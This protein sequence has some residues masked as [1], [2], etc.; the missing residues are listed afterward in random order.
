MKNKLYALSF[1]AGS[2]LLIMMQGCQSTGTNNSNSADVVVYGGTA[3]AVTAAVQLA[4]MDKSVIIVCPDI[5][6][7]GMS[8]SGLGFTDTGNKSVIGGLS[9]EFYQR[10]YNNYQKDEAWQWQ[11]R[12]EYG[13]KGQG[14]PAIDG[15]NRT[16]WIFEP[17]VAEQI[18]EDFISE[19]NIVVYRDKWLDRTG[20]VEMSDGRIVSVTMTDGTNY[21]GK[22][23]I[24]ATYEG[25]LMAAAGISYHVGRE[26]NSVYNEEWNGVQVGVLHHRHHFAEMKVSPYV[27]PGDSSSGILPLISPDDPGKKGEGDNRLQAYCFRTCLT[28]VIEN[29]IPFERPDNYDS[30]QYELL[31]RVLDKGWRETFDKFD[32]IPNHKTDVN[33]HGPFSFDYIGMNYDYPEASYE[34]RAEIIKEHET[35]QKGLLYFYTHD[36]RIL[37]DIRTEMNRWGLSKDEFKDNGNWPHQIYVREARR[38]T[39]DFV[40]TE[41]EVL[42]KKK[43]LKSIG[44]GSYTLDSHNAQRYIMEDGSVQNE[45]DIGIEAEKPYQIDMGSILPKKAEC[46]NLIVPVAVSCSHIAFGSIRMEP[47]FMILGQSAAIIAAM[48]IEENLQIHDLNYDQIK[49]KLTEAGQVLS[50]VE[51]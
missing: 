7:G 46:S 38:M 2:V 36:P 37:A 28:T 26:A 14:T 45:G 33:N 44:M 6:L 4:R 3:A 50:Q 47:V 19:N 40:M 18:F 21:R 10:V 32:P 42:G 30:T 34:R 23:F 31:I 29:Q 12:A 15:S 43:V 48:A 39:G 20:G 17:H 41:N 25:D 1:I 51:E 49:V 16:M 24:D 8:S 35:Y 5:H 27:I 22:V 11:T 13:N 9:R